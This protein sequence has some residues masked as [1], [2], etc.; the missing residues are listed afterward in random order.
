MISSFFFFSSGVF[1]FGMF[2]LFPKTEKRISFLTWC[3]PAFLLLECYACAVGGVLT[4]LT[5]PADKITIGI[6][7]VALGLALFLGMRA[8]KARQKFSLDG[9]NVLALVVCFLLVLAIPIY[10]LRH[11]CASISKR[12]IPQFILNWQWTR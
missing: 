5:L 10:V 8:K 1:L 7:N 3:A 12:A 9:G 4:A 2:L 11:N 6:A